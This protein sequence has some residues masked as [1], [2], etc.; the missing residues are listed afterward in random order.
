MK[1][2]VMG[3]GVVGVTTA[4]CLL[5]D[6]HEVTVVERHDGAADETSFANAGLVAPGHAYTWASP[7]A[8]KI[9][10]KSLW[11]NDQALRFRL[12]LDP[13]L[14][15]WSL[16]F[17]GNC[18][19][20]RVA[21]NTARK[22]RLSL[23]SQD[24]LHEVVEDTGVAFDG[25][26]GGLLYLY[27]TPAA[28]DAGV[29]KMKILTDNGLPL[30]VVDRDRAAA[31]DP[32]LLPTKDRIVGGIYAPSDES[33]DARLFTRN[34]ADWCAE[35]GVRFLYGTTISGVETAAGEVTGL[36]TDKGRLTADAYV[37]ALGCQSAALAKPLGLSLPI[38]P[39]K[40][41]SVTVPVAGR[42]NTPRIGGVDEENL[43]AY[44]PMGDRLRI[45]ATA[46]FAGYDKRH[47]PADFQT[48]LAA[49]R[50]LFPDAADYSR[51][52]YWAGLRPMT[53][54]GTPIFGRGRQRNL[55][56]NTGHGH[57]GWTMSCGSAR[58]TADLIAG[59]IPAIPLDG[60]QAVH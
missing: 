22:V 13:A 39:I 47:S 53:P 26:K 28:F 30:E 8:P 43:V 37:L 60:M 48:M 59:R 45:T 3:S 17:L 38:Y 15:S 23:Y 9:L 56:L 24:M 51:P 18:R 10:L 42:N 27:R 19:A 1:V 55:F 50:D 29:A 7:K 35:R 44:A 58:I 2:I 20:E 33:G 11:R 21:V 12:R 32:A 46:D 57:M 49:A 25:A 40:G 6:G 52:S 16:K 36:L 4:Y 31:I 14:W 34:L 5:K 41:Y 54:E